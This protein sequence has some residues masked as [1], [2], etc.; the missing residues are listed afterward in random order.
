MENERRDKFNT[1]TAM[2]GRESQ[3]GF[4]G[5]VQ[6]SLDGKVEDLVDEALEDFKWA[7]AFQIG[8][9]RVEMQQLVSEAK[10]F[11]KREWK[12]P[13]EPNIVFPDTDAKV[14]DVLVQH[15]NAVEADYGIA[16][17][18]PVADADIIAGLD[19][20]R[21]NT[22]TS[23]DTDG[24]NLKTAGLDNSSEHVSAIADFTGKADDADSANDDAGEGMDP[25]RGTKRRRHSSVMP[26]IEFDPIDTSRPKAKRAKKDNAAVSTQRP[27]PNAP[28]PQQAIVTEL[29]S[30]GLYT[31]FDQPQG[32]NKA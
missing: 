6:T 17:A 27:S 19:G 10:A 24:D 4:Q 32:P 15:I 31:D 7:V 8:K 3:V 25:Q 23:P 14:L 16:A 29:P 13:G 9:F 30:S 28:N 12:G 18:S 20:A 26:S 21:D 11:V 1:L 2:L 22:A 5:L